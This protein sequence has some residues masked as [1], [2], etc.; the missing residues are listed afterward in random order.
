M[1]TF[2]EQLHRNTKIAQASI[3]LVLACPCLSWLV[4][5]ALHFRAGVCWVLPKG[6]RGLAFASIRGLGMD[7]GKWWAA[8]WAE[9]CAGASSSMGAA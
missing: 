7:L 5:A 6:G 9:G 1:N 4:H 3:F 8:G 2:Y